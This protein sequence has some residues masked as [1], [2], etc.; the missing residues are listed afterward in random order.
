[1][2]VRVI[3]KLV[4]PEYLWHGVWA[5]E[6]QAGIVALCYTLAWTNP[7]NIHALLPLIH[8]GDALGRGILDTGVATF[9][10]AVARTWIDAML[11]GRKPR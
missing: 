10:Y 7:G 3:R 11:G 5:M 1:M 2:V 8:W 9:P 4:N 6:I